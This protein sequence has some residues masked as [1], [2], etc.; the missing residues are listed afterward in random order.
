MPWGIHRQHPIPNE[1]FAPT[2]RLGAYQSALKAVDVPI[3]MP[4]NATAH[5]RC[6]SWKHGLLRT[7]VSIWSRRGHQRYPVPLRYPAQNSGRS[8]RPSNINRQLT[9]D[10]VVQVHSG[11]GF[12]ALRRA[13]RQGH[14]YPTN[15]HFRARLRW[16]RTGQ[17]TPH[18]HGCRLS[19]RL[20]SRQR[21]PGS[22]QIRNRADKKPDPEKKKTD[23]ERSKNKSKARKTPRKCGRWR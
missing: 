7:A 10:E 16:R 13:H 22:D 3:T 6:T 17:Q 19:P 8:R 18:G 12:Q 14:P 23:L 2:Q 4:T 9:P 1:P 5:S 11:R 21:E 20:H 15:H